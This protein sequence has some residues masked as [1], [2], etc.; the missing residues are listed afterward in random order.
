MGAPIAPNGLKPV[1]V[2]GVCCDGV[3]SGQ[4]GTPVAGWP[5]DPYM[6]PDPIGLGPSSANDTLCVLGTGLNEVNDGVFM[7][8]V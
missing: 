1:V 2:K 5:L 8:G 7:T 6:T 3:G 4:I